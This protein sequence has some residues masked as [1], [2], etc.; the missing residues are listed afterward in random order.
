MEK[1]KTT[2]SKKLSRT[3]L[4][5]ILIDNF[6]NLQKVLTNL[7]VKFEDLSSNITKLLQLFEISAKSFGEKYS[8]NDVKKQTENDTEFVE[9]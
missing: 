5:K 3:E 9:N 6:I 1:T 8:N 2:K 4:D 7:S